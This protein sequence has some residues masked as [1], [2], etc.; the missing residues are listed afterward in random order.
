MSEADLAGSAPVDRR[1]LDDHLAV[2]GAAG[3][4]PQALDEAVDLDG[5]C[6]GRC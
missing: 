1:L 2:Y 6:P 4:E 5:G 3:L